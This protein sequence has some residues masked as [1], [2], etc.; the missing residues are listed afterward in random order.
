MKNATEQLNIVLANVM[1]VFVRIII[2]FLNLGST[3]K[4]RTIWFELC[5]K[6]LTT[7]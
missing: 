3:A 5:D 2:N 6:N 7:R 1:I 4:R